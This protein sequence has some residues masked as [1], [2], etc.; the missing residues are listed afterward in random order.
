MSLVSLL[1]KHIFIPSVEK[2]AEISK[3]A[4]DIKNSLE[5]RFSFVKD[6]YQNHYPELMQESAA[7]I[8]G[9][10][11]K[12][13]HADFK[14]EVALVLGSGWS[15][16]VG[17]LLEE[18][19]LEL[20]YSEIP[21]FPKPT[22]PG[23]NGK[24]VFGYI[25]GVAVVIMEGR[26]HLYEVNKM[27]DIAANIIT[28]PVDILKLLGVKTYFATNAAGGLRPKILSLAMKLGYNPWKEG[29]QVGEPM[30]I[31]GHENRMGDNPI[32]GDTYEGTLLERNRFPPMPDAYD[33]TLMGIL[34]K[35]AKRNRIRMNEGTYL[36]VPGNN[37]E[38]TP[39][40]K[41]FRKNNSAVGMSTVPEVLLARGYKV[42][43]KSGLDERL[44]VVG[45][46]CIT[47]L[48]GPDGKNITNHEEVTNTLKQPEVKKRFQ[49]LILGF[50][51]EYAH[52]GNR[53]RH[54]K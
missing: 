22:V 23:H 15:D 11:E 10:L 5:D 8:N 24:L 19:V 30:L 18:R 49:D 17:E 13:G 45:L 43:Y 54:I 14:P 31:T 50:F 3:T 32:N 2:W 34:R 7:Y 44:N 39:E 35:V 47:N 38:T 40:V 6:Y 16:L 53:Y 42:D 48:V 37:Y 27:K 41:S 4:R 29:Q 1:E 26:K 20:D 25:N 51:A 12:E 28:S 36:G 52:L 33:S 21:Y 9:K 46:T